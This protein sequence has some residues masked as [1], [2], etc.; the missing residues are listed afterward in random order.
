MDLRN[1]THQ[2]R[3]GGFGDGRLGVQS[4]DLV[5]TLFACCC[6]RAGLLR[7]AVCPGRGLDESGN[8]RAEDAHNVSAEDNGNMTTNK[9]RG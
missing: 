9:H 1:G 6:S 3:V 8:G 2:T 4:F 5:G 7:R